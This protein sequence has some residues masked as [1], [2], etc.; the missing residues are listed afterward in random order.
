VFFE[1]SPGLYLVLDPHLVI[2]AVS[3]AYNEATMTKR[4]EIIGRHLFDVFP[5]NPDQLD[6]DGVSNLHASL[7]RVLQNK[8][9]DTMTIQRYDVRK[10]E[11]EGGE[12]EVR[13]WSPM[14]VPIFCADDPDR[15]A[16]IIHRVKDATEL[17]LLRE[18]SQMTEGFQTR[19]EQM[20][21]DILNRTRELELARKTLEQQNKELTS[22]YEEMESFSYS[23]SHDLRTPLRA[24]N[25]YGTILDREY[26]N[27]L[28]DE[29]KRFIRNIKDNT[30][31]MSV[32]IDELLSLAYLGR[33]EIKKTEVDMNT[34]ANRLVYDMAEVTN[35]RTEFIIEE[36]HTASADPALMDHVFTNLLSNAIKY[37]S[38]KDRPS[39]KIWSYQE[40]PEVIYAVR[41]NGAG[42]DMAYAGKLFGVFERLHNKSEYDGIGIGLAIVKRVIQRHNGRVWAEGRVNDGA[43]FYVS[44]PI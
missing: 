41:D 40:G 15:I 14:N 29:G 25:G 1:K 39:I 4:D 42:F 31:R 3:D 23:V 19:I 26:S 36:L 28:D 12:F 6:A 11:S 35:A 16:F 7:N 30:Q 18:K 10:P 34:L 5:D 33:A 20:E 27:K 8:K 13:Y 17:I 32:M 2:V 24:I 9:P 38:K 21:I 37:S 44:L 43:T 22:S